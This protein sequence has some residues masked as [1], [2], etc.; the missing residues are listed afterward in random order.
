VGKTLALPMG[1]NKTCWEII[2]KGQN[3]SSFS[4]VLLDRY[5]LMQLLVGP[6]QFE[7]SKEENM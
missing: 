5:F 4:L 6:K 7:I 2:S 1:I 3:S